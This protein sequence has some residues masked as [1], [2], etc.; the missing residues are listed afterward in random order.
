[1]STSRSHRPL[2]AFVAALLAVMAVPLAAVPAPAAAEAGTQAI[3]TGADR[4]LQSVMAD[5]AIA[6][7][8]DRTKIRPYLGHFAAI[9]LA[10]AYRTTRDPRY[11]EPVWRWLSWYQDHMDGAGYVTDFD[12]VGGVMVSTGDMD[13]TDSYAGMFLVAAYRAQ[14][15]TGDRARSAGL[16][17][18][19]AKAVAA[20]GSTQQPDGLTWAKPSYRAKYLMD[21]AETYAGLRAGAWLATTVLGDQELAGRA[22]RMADAL[23]AGVDGLWNPGKGAYDWARH[24]NGVQTVT[25]WGVLYPDALSQVWAVAFGLVDNDRGRAAALL[26][27]FDSTHPSWDQPAAIDVFDLGN[28]AVEYWPV[29]GWAFAR[30]GEQGRADAAAAS[31]LTGAL[32]ANWAWPFHS[33]AMGQLVFLQ[34]KGD[35]LFPTAVAQVVGRDPTSPITTRKK[36]DVTPAPPADVMGLTV[37]TAAPALRA[38][39]ATP[40]AFAPVGAIK[41]P[42]VT[43]RNLRALLQASF[44]R[45]T[46]P[47]FLSLWPVPVV[48]AF[49]PS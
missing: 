46:W 35:D 42:G 34:A 28:H 38:P 22:T 32:N 5:G 4:L 7:Y 45:L 30:I 8:T 6:Q 9:G 19:V 27:R 2:W 25:N 47:W 16:R 3:V 15:V 23:K 18:G 49:S 11:I 39:V 48:V 26:Q 36:G 31:I 29:A 14:Q 44:D 43:N 41:Q 33:M 1:M 40:R 24:E 10:E 13:S 17:A 21:Q 37:T 20:I 12:Q